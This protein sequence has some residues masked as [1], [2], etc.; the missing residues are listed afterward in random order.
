MR[1]NLTGTQKLNRNK[2]AYIY[3]SFVLMVTT[4][5]KAPNIIT[6]LHLIK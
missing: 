2:S 5:E 4:D 3:T 1:D 6:L